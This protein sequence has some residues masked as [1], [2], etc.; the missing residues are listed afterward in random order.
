[1]RTTAPLR[2]A[3]VGLALS[4]VIAGAPAAVAVP[5]DG[6]VSFLG[7]Y[8]SGTVGV[9]AAEIPAYDPLTRRVFVVNAQDGTVDMLDIRNPRAPRKVG[10]L[11]APGAN[12]VAVHGGLA[13]VAQQAADK[14]APGSV[15]FFSTV[16]GGRLRQV[17]VGA[18]PDMLTFSSDG[19]R[20]VV[21]NEGEPSS[22]CPGEV[23]DPEGSVS[24]IDV[25]T[26]SVRTAGFRSWNGR[27]DEL[28]TK[29][30]RISGPGSSAAQDLEP[31]Y[32][33]LNGD[34]A[35]VTLQENNALAVIDLEK[36]EVRDILPLGLKDHSQAGNGMDASDRDG[37]IDIRPRPARACTCPTRSPTSK[38]TGRASW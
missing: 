29:G 22:Y 15:T 24:V 26:G 17:T 11:T 12:S 9:S 30:V 19:R 1:M 23:N 27:E 18:Q 13:A 6:Q 33:A 34:T 5:K 36:A 20:V 28:R 35:W 37:K 2:L 38:R 3:V 10:S 25:R 32:V 8:S 21:A 7:R 16:T 31:E 14:T 4:S